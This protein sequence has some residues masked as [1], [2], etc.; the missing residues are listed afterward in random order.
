MNDPEGNYGYTKKNQEQPKTFPGSAD[1]K[2]TQKLGICIEKIETQHNLNIWE[3][4][5]AGLA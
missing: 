1:K 2:E 5:M 3:S 4:Y